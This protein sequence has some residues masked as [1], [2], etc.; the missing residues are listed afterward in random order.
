MRVSLFLVGV[1]EYDEAEDHNAFADMPVELENRLEDPN[2]ENGS[3]VIFKIDYVTERYV[4][5]SDVDDAEYSPVKMEEWE[6]RAEKEALDIMVGVS[7][8]IQN[9]WQG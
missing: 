7:D 2:V 5:Y 8:V 9:Q 4:D 6:V 1:A 3:P